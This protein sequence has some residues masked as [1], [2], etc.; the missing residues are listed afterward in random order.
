MVSR[1]LS[2]LS[3]VVRYIDRDIKRRLDHGVFEHAYM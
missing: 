3:D 2:G 1:S